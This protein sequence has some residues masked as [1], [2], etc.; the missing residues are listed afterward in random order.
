LTGQ[1]K[2]IVTIAQPERYANI[3]K[4]IRKNF[5]VAEDRSFQDSARHLLVFR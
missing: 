1:G 3:L 4:M 2:I 5:Q